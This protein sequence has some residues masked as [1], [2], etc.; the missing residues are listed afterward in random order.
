MHRRAPE[1]PAPARGRQTPAATQRAP[2]DAGGQPAERPT[3]ERPRRLR[4]ALGGYR[5]ALAGLELL[6]LF[7]NFNYVLGFSSFAT[8]NFFSYFTIQSA[9]IAVVVL[10]TGGITA[11]LRPRDPHWLSIMR[12]VTMCYLLVSGIVFAVIVAQASSHA[13]RIEVP[14][15][16]TL[17]H[18]VVPV[19]ALLGWFVDAVISPRSDPM[20]WS[21]LGWVLPFPTLWLV[22][23]L[24][25]GADV[26]WYPY[27][28][29]DP[30]QVG[31]PLGIAFYCLLVLGIFLGVS[32]LLVAVSRKVTA[33]ATSLR[34]RLLRENTAQ[35]KPAPWQ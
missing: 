27:F 25:R 23:T 10:I 26:G 24:V 7:G 13:Y 35:E 15:S 11:L 30:A 17:L 22:F 16:D 2:A 34:E 31:G 3:A 33:R 29:L 21:T 20:P 12:T 5:L 19:L 28:F 8:N 14:W 6:A 9:M 32:A 1:P 18:F 4:I